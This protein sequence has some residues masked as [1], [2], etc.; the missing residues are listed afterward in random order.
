MP[1]LWFE[2]GTCGISDLD[3][4]RCYHYTGEGDPFYGGVRVEVFV[5]SVKVRLLQ[6]YLAPVN[7]SG[8]W[9]VMFLKTLYPNL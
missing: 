4:K 2:I 8:I 1:P 3:L 7:W 9:F 5:A 6:T